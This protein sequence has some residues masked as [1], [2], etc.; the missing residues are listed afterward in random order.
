MCR[1]I[2]A[3]IRRFLSVVALVAASLREVDV[4]DLLFH[5]LAPRCSMP[6]SRCIA[7]S[8]F[9]L[10]TKIPDIC[11]EGEPLQPLRCRSSCRVPYRGVEDPFLLDFPDLI[12]DDMPF[13]VSSTTGTVPTA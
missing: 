13:P 2:G 1:T 3:H 8:P 6:L 9:R 11:A 7:T 4:Y 10:Q 12:L 5:L